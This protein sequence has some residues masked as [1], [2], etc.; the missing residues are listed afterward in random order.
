VAYAD[1][2]EEDHARLS[3]EIEAGRL[4]VVQDTHPVARKATRVDA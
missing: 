2:N 4:E 3:A 1:L